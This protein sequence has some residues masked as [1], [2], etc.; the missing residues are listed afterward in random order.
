MYINQ[1]AFLRKEI[2]SP[3]FSSSHIIIGLLAQPD[4]AQKLE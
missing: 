4:Q 3:I 2:K 1:V